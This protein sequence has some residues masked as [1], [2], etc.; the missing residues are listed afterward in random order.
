MLPTRMST[1][2][3]ILL[4]LPPFLMFEFDFVSAQ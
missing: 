3:F 1:Q 4:E 2:A